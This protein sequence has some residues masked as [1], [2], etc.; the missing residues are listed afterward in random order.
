MSTRIYFITGTR[1]NANLRSIAVAGGQSEEVLRNVLRADLSPDGKTMAV[2]VAAAPGQPYRLAFSSPPGAPPLPYAQAPLSN[3]TASGIVASIQFDPSSSYLGLLTDT[4]GQPEFWKVPVNGRPPEWLMFPGAYPMLFSW[5]RD[6]ARIVA[7]GSVTVNAPLSIIDLPSGITRAITSGASRETTPSVSPDGET[8]AFASGELGHDIMEMP[9]EGSAPRTVISTARAEISPAWHPDGIRFAYSTD[10]SGAPEIW[11]RN[12]ADGSERRIAGGG[13]F[14]GVGA[15]LDCAISPAGDRVAYRVSRSRQGGLPS[16]WISPL[17]GEAPAKFWNDP[18]NSPQRGPSWSPDGNWI[19]FY[20]V[21]DGKLAVMKARV[22]GGEPP[23]LLAY[24][25]TNRPI[26]WSPRGDWIV[27]RDGDTL[28][29]VSQDG[30]QNRLVSERAWEAYGWSKDG[31]ALYGIGAGENRRLILARIDVATE[32]ERQ[33]ADLGQFPPESDFISATS[34]DLFFRGFSLHPDG[35]SFLT[36]MAAGEDADLPDERFR[37]HRAAIRSLVELSVMTLAAGAKLGP[38]EIIAPIGAGGMGEV[39]RALDTRLGREVAIKVSAAQFTERF[40]REARAVAALN[41]PNIC[42]LYDVG[43]NYLVM[44]YV[45]GAPVAPVDSPRK[46]LDIAVQIADG[47]A[48]AHAAG[49]VHRDLKPDNILVTREGRV[50]I[51][52]FGLAKQAAAAS[53][54]RSHPHHPGH[55]ARDHQLHESGAGARRRKRTRA[56]T[57][58]PSA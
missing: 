15:L 34:N 28:R 2:M 38:Y 9:V 29:I 50:K 49:I 30:K 5:S 40:E 37:S 7:A 20:G 18:L 31:A 24:M 33:I 25:A 21:R 55:C 58:F 1:A 17:S 52:D 6:G 47:L 11:L 39:Y 35:K 56:A 8:L 32:R 12:R 41:H 45:E 26:Y 14:P 16:I 54:D 57:S 19:A 36:S 53:R 44:E 13:E 3:L 51:L 23:E 22:G 27:Y 42:T 48:A 4:R 46:L 43:P 10:R